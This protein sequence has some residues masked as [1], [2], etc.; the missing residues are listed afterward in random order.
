VLVLRHEV[1]SW[2]LCHHAAGIQVQQVGVSIPVG[3]VEIP[4]HL[5]QPHIQGF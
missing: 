5:L 1:H 4:C 3:G 2:T